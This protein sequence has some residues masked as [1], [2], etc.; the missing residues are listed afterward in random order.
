VE[1]ELAAALPV[2]EELRSVQEAERARALL[3]TVAV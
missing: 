1:R 3:A 2:F